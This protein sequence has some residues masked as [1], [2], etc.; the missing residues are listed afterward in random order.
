MVSVLWPPPWSWILAGRTRLCLCMKTTW[1]SWRTWRVWLEAAILRPT[2]AGIW[3]PTL[4][5]VA[6]RLASSTAPA[7]PLWTYRHQVLQSLASS[8]HRAQRFHRPRPPVPSRTATLATAIILAEWGGVPSNPVRS[9][10]HSATLQKNTW[11]PRSHLKNILAGLKSSPFTTATPV[12]TSPW[13]VIWT[14]RW[15]RRLERESRDTIVSYLWT[16][17]NLGLWL[18]DGVVR[19]IAPRTRARR[20]IS[21]SLR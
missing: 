21:G 4:L 8:A 3:W 1:M 20:V 6:T 16:A 17:I 2:S 7:I 11:I 13:P 10:V 9:R 12:P 18:T 19:C 14:C 5:W 15:Y